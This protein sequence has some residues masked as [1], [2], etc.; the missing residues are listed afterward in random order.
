MLFILE[1]LL[2][3]LLVITFNRVF[4]FFYF[5]GSGSA[6]STQTSAA[7]Q[8]TFSQELDRKW[9]EASQQLSVVLE[10]GGEFLTDIVPFDAA[11]DVPIDDQK[12]VFSTEKIR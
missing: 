5:P 11:S 3:L 8:L 9:D 6:Q 7:S 4:Y 10:G 12:Y 1:I 2:I